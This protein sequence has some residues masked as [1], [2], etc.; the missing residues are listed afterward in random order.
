MCNFQ[1]SI[2][3]FCI[4]EFRGTSS[5]KCDKRY[6]F[7]LIKI[8]TLI[9]G[10]KRLFFYVERGSNTNTNRFAKNLGLYSATR[11]SSNTTCVFVCSF[12]E[13][14]SGM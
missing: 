8:Y 2:V 12:K 1:D 9:R 6:I 7:L 13:F 11:G 10:S 14:F 4:S 3:A 5:Y